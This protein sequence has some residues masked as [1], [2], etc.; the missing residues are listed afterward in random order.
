MIYKEWDR[1]KDL[2]EKFCR[3]IVILPE[4]V[5]SCLEMKVMIVKYIYNRYDFV[6]CCT[7]EI[8]VN[9]SLIFQID[10]K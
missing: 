10:I 2:S 6:F 8:K 1:T 4:M 3:N 7:V 5:F 9:D